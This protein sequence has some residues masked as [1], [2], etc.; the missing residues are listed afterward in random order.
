MP[1]IRNDAEFQIISLILSHN[2]VVKS[3]PKLR[4]DLELSRQPG[5]AGVQFVVRDPRNGSIYSFPEITY[6]LL[7]MADGTLSV[8]ILTERLFGRAATASEREQVRSLFDKVAAMG[9]FESDSTTDERG[10]K[11][12]SSGRRGLLWKLVDIQL[13]PLVISFA[14]TLG[15]LF[16]KAGSIA[17]MIWFGMVV[18]TTAGKL[19]QYWN[20]LQVFF[21]YAFWP[22]TIATVLLSTVWHELGHL[23]AATRGGARTARFGM[24]IYLFMPTA[25]VRIDDFF[26]IPTRAGR[27]ITSMG[28]IYFDLISVSICLLLWRYT[29]NF[30]M[31]NQVA[32]VTSYL[33]LI[34]IA[35]NLLPILRLDGYWAFTEL[36]GIRHLREEGFSALLSAIPALRERL[37][38]GKL[39]GLPRLMA[40]VYSLLISLIFV[41]ITSSVYFYLRR[42]IVGWWPA[43]GE[44]LSIALAL[45]MG[46][47]LIRSLTR[48]GQRAV[49]LGKQE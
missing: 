4:T 21:H 30:T 10:A 15:V 28:G 48:E 42:I 26:M 2:P 34:R 36:I 16:S 5:A 31:L 44:I 47:M 24:G 43:Y 6:K 9:L 17:V 11:K 12:S 29:G 45:V 46:G 25:Y 3:S 20:M 22:E 49:R 32:L 13:P 1:L 38:S 19:G 35:F 39:Q 41:I 33:L 18:A 8:P 27:V 23:A 7:S 37:G 14:R 40:G